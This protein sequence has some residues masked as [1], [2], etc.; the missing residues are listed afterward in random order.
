MKKYKALISDFDGTMAGSNGEISVTVLAKIRKL[1]DQ[2][3][4]FS[5]ATGRPYFGKIKAVC[6]ELQLTSPQIAYGGAEI[7]LPDGDKILW[8]RYLPDTEVQDLIEY[9][10]DKNIYFILEKDNYI[11]TRDG[12]N[13]FYRDP[14][15]FKKVKDTPL[16]NISKIVIS[17]L[18]NKLSLEEI[19]KI[20][21][22]L[23]KRYKNIHIIKG[24]IGD[25]Y[26]LDITAEQAS[27]HISVLELMKLLD[28]QPEE[29]VGIGDGYNDYPLLTACGLKI[30]MGNAPNELKEIADFVVPTQQEDGLATAIDKYF[31]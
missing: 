9:F 26:G 19:N 21:E 18:V 5:I 20:M 8:G 30:A 6:E 11:L 14:F 31:L 25:H 16:K 7:R 22:E 3:Y 4:I 29:V 13:A 10:S 17:S 15:I 24:K 23:Q 28:L 27:K 2:G 1:I 12:S